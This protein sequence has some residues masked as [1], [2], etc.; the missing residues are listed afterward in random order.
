VALHGDYGYDDNTL[1]TVVNATD[2]AIGKMEFI[3]REVL[4]MSAALPTVNIST[5]GQKLAARIGDWTYEF[6]QVL[7]A[8]RTLNEKANGLLKTNRRVETD[9]TQHS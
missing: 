4:S 1:L 6:G 2:D 5:S 7:G 3:N 8:L 9:T